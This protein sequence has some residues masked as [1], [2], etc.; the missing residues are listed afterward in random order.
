MILNDNKKIN[1]WFWLITSNIRR[2]FWLLVTYFDSNEY[3]VQNVWSHVD[4]YAKEY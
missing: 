2:P 4:V 3:Y 1:V